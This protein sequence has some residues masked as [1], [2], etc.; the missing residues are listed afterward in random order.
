MWC[1][2]ASWTNNSHAA[3]YTNHYKT[4]IQPRLSGKTIMLKP[5]WMLSFTPTNHWFSNSTINLDKPGSCSSMTMQFNHIYYLYL[6]PC[7]CKSF[8]CSN[9]KQSLLSKRILTQLNAHFWET[10][11]FFLG[12]WKS[13]ESTRKI[14]FCFQCSLQSYWHAEKK[15]YYKKSSFWPCYTLQCIQKKV[16]YAHC[17]KKM[18]AFC[19][20]EA[21][22]TPRSF[23]GL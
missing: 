5:D 10:G 3:I 11:V 14:I 18:P 6:M 1:L 7:K 9:W 2:L 19:S 8:L 13:P 15:A 16:N 21:G 17:G 20:V 12:A 22:D 23:Y 4:C